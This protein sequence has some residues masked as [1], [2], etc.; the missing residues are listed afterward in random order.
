M[1][2]L[3]GHH[4]PALAVTA[5][6]VDHLAEESALA[7]VHGGHHQGPA[8]TNVHDCVTDG[9]GVKFVWGHRRLLRPSEQHHRRRKHTI[10]H[11][12]PPL[13]VVPRLPTGPSGAVR[14]VVTP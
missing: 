5:R 1:E 4:D 2:F 11:V 13:T 6:R 14:P 8:G 9:E 3:G 7:R 12:A 10:A